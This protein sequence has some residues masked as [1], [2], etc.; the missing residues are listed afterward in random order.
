M[1]SLP[2]P[3][4]QFLEAYQKTVLNKDLEAFMRLYDESLQVFDMWG[5]DWES[6]GLAPWR[7]L[8][9]EWFSSL[10]EEKVA[11]T[12]EKVLGSEQNGTAYFSAF[13][14]FAALSP[15]NKVLRFLHNRMT[16]ILVL[17]N[18][19]WKMVHQHT[20]GPI[21]PETLKVALQM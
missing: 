10:G 17:K 20:S 14:K 7:A 16:G 13:V 2:Q 15:E 8:T 21:N 19:E 6:I 11:V 12:F 9:E 1:N 3:V 4:S 5:P 18:G